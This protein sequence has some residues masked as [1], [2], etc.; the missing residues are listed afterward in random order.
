M[1]KDEDDELNR[2]IVPE[3]NNDF[4]SQDVDQDETIT[5]ET[6]SEFD[7][8][9]ENIPLSELA[10]KLNPGGWRSGN[11]TKDPNEIKFLGIQNML[12]EVVELE[13]SLTFYLQKK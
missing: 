5:S 7:D 11:F 2:I 12:Q 9:E 8:N 3:S 6:D 4:V 10:E 13:N 1:S